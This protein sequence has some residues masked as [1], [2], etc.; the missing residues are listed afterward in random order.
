QS[1]PRGPQS[2]DRGN[3]NRAARATLA[4]IR[5]A[6]DWYDASRISGPRVL[7][8]NGR[9]LER[10]LGEFQAYYNEVRCH[11]SLEGHTPLTFASGRRVVPADLSNVRWVS[12]CCDLVELPA[13]A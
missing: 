10:K 4:P 2:R 6:L 12:H 1:S 5:G 13:A 9:D 11:S 3:Q 7:F 8:W